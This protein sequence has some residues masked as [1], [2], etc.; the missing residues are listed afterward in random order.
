MKNLKYIFLIGV[1]LTIFNSCE[2]SI[3]NLEDPGAPTDA[4]FFSTES[5]LEV[6]LAGVYQSL[7]YVRVV[8]FPH[9]TNSQWRSDLH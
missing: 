3:L 5:Q 2:E 4:T 6:A 7:N 9:C 1:C 8:P